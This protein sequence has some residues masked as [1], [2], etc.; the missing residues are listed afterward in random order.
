MGAWKKGSGQFVRKKGGKVGTK[1]TQ[2]R[3]F[4]ALR[5]A[6]AWVNLKLTGGEVRPDLSQAAILLYWAGRQKEA[7]ELLLGRERAEIETQVAE[8]DLLWYHTIFATLL[9]PAEEKR[10]EFLGRFILVADQHQW[11][12]YR[13][14]ERISIGI[15]PNEYFVLSE[16]L[17][18]RLRFLE[19]R[20]ETKVEARVAELTSD[21]YRREIFTRIA[22]LTIA[23]GKRLLELPLIIEREGGNLSRIRLRE[24][25]KS[26]LAQ[27]LRELGEALKR[28][29]K[30]EDFYRPDF[31]LPVSRVLRE[32]DCRTPG[33]SDG[34]FVSVVRLIRDRIRGKGIYT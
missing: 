26:S 27:A 29:L 9:Q 16:R 5:L 17:S 3:Q 28:G 31:D 34:V 7:F 33:S 23:E 15:Y 6:Y 30:V 11:A 8:E 20:A 13:P 18:R 10:Q 19:A 24:A 14:A 4:Q 22:E 12:S 25:Q 2:H 32:I 1:T 21:A